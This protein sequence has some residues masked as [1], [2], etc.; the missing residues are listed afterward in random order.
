M[1][2]K[3]LDSTLNNL[4][5]NLKKHWELKKQKN[6]L[7]LVVK[8]EEN[9]SLYDSLIKLSG[10]NNSKLNNILNQIKTKNV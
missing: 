4:D 3:Y 9:I 1:A 5:K 8:L 2:G 10:Y 7:D 6:G